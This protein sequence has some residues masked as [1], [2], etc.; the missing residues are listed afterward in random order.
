MLYEF[1]DKFKGIRV[2]DTIKVKK[3]CLP[4][5]SS[6]HVPASVDVIEWINRYGNHFKVDG[7]QEI[8]NDNAIFTLY[9]V[10]GVL[11]YYQIVYYI[12]SIRVINF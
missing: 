5:F 7:I 3:E 2:G 10:K 11:D 12:D 8:E 1:V 9:E 6:T 4:P